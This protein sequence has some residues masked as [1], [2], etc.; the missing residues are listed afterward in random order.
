M[1]LKTLFLILLSNNLRDILLFWP[2]FFCSKI[3][4]I[5]KFL[6]IFFS[7]SL[8]ILLI[9]IMLTFLGSEL[10]PIIRLPPNIRIPSEIFLGVFRILFRGMRITVIL[11][12]KIILLPYLFSV[13]NGISI[14]SFCIVN[15]PSLSEALF[16]S[17]D[18]IFSIKNRQNFWPH[19]PPILVVIR[20]LFILKFKGVN[21]SVALKI[22]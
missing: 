4:K 2:F 3:Q 8:Y 13:I 17:F 19:F 18:H 11:V 20:A 14:P 5:R 12:I 21:R 10:I 16:L 7:W 1:L 15:V 9:P 22:R 6:I